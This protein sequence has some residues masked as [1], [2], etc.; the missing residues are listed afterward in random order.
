MLFEGTNR[1][2]VYVEVSY[3]NEH[4]AL[5]YIRLLFRVFQTFLLQVTKVN[6]DETTTID[7]TVPCFGSTTHTCLVQVSS[8]TRTVIRPLMIFMFFS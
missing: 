2:D 8:S 4:S 6:V 1:V 5:R 3:R 7:K